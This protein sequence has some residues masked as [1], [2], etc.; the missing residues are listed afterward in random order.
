MGLFNF[1]SKKKRGEADAVA[2]DEVAPADTEATSSTATATKPGTE[3]A[4]KPNTTAALD[5]HV[6]IDE[7]AGPATMPAPVTD[8]RI[9]GEPAPAENPSRPAGLIARL[10]AKL[11]RGNSWLT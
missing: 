5:A 8:A 10:R 11:N 3:G 9:S 4:A 1:R 2:P 7:R 6:E